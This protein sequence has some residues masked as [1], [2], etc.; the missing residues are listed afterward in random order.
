MAEHCNLL[1]KGLVRFCTDCGD[2]PCARLKRL[3]ARYRS[4]YHMS[5]I[6]N[7]EFIRDNG[8]ERFLGKEAAKWRCA[9]CGG[10]MCCHNGLC[11]DCDLDKLRRNRKYRWGEQ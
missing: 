9:Q 10:V 11:L 2:Y 4:R 3:D 8:I 1:A 6:E 7:L 5:M